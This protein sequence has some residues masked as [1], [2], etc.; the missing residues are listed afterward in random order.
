MSPSTR[1]KR[2]D[3][4][5]QPSRRSARATECRTRRRGARHRAPRVPRSSPR[6]DAASIPQRRCARRPGRD[7]APCP[8]RHRGP[9][10]VMMIT[11][12]STRVHIASRHAPHT[13]TTVTS[14]T[15][16]PS[17]RILAGQTVVITGG[18]SGIGRA[19]AQR[20]A[21]EG[22]AVAVLDRNAAG[23]DETVALIAADG[24]AASA[25][26]CD[27]ADDGQIAS[28]VATYRRRSRADRRR[29]HRRRH[30]PRT[31]P[32]TSASSPRSKTS[33]AY[34]AST[35]S[36]R[37]RSSS[38]RFRCSIDGGGAIVT[39]AS[40][41]AIRGHGYGAGYTASKGGVDALTRSA[42]GPIR[43]ARRTRE[44][45]LPRW[46]RHADDQRCVCKCGS[47]TTRARKS[48]DRSLRTGRRY[49]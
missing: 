21:H 2:F 47:A 46:C 18:G 19:T 36:A 42:G 31:R 27:V 24:G 20:A 33:Y 16:E 28:T 14:P 25:Y 29:R 45:H 34:C 48:S 26:A 9:T 39:I 44:L 17:S 40:T 30:L 35:W 8:C 22:A 43:R 38:M 12:P 13:T 7:A 32:P 10:P 1:P 49:R 15:M 5:A 41:A 11:L 3:C 23:A 4:H 37:S 6:A